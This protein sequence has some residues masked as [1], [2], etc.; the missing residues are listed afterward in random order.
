MEKSSTRFQLI[1]HLFHHSLYDENFY[2]N[3]INKFIITKKDGLKI[4]EEINIQTDLKLIV[5]EGKEASIYVGIRFQDFKFFLE[6]IAP[7]RHGYFKQVG[8]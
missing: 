3:L 4:S 2:W 8:S 6:V 7:N 1:H 5:K